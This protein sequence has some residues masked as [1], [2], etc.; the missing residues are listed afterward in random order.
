MNA[1]SCM[2]LEIQTVEGGN[3]PKLRTH[4]S[5]ADHQRL[6]LR[7]RWMIYRRR[8]TRRKVYFNVVCGVH[9]SN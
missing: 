8:E 4:R 5:E 2:K 6:G 1:P 3:G 7:V 9:S